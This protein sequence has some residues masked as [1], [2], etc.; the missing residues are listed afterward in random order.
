L[1]AQLPLAPGRRAGPRP[2]PPEPDHE[3]GRGDAMHGRHDPGVRDGPWPTRTPPSRVH[4]RQRPNPAPCAT[5]PRL[6]RRPMVA[7]RER[8]GPNG[9]VTQR[10]VVVDDRSHDSL[11]CWRGFPEGGPLV[12]VDKEWRRAT[13]WLSQP[14]SVRPPERPRLSRLCAPRSRTR[15]SITGGR[16]LS[17]TGGRGDGRIPDIVGEVANPCKLC[18][19]AGPYPLFGWLRSGPLPRLARRKCCWAD[20]RRPIRPG[21]QTFGA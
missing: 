20:N 12:P 18:M 19:H 17:P 7:R 9:G 15:T 11:L 13:A 6:A 5:R 10:P 1:R 14:R 21:R 2:I 4:P 16:A 3:R 8:P